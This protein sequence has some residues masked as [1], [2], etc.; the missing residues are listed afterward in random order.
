MAL[1]AGDI[2]PRHQKPRLFQ[3][4]AADRVHSVVH[5]PAGRY[6]TIRHHQVAVARICGRPAP[7]PH[8]HA[9]YRD[10]APRVTPTRLLNSTLRRFARRRVPVD[11]L[12]HADAGGEQLWWHRRRRSP[13]F[14]VDEVMYHGSPC[15]RC[16]RRREAARRAIAARA[17]G[18]G[19]SPPFFHRRGAAR[20]FKI[21]PP[22]RP[23]AR[24]SGAA[25]SAMRRTA[26]GY[27]A[28]RR[29]TAI[30][31][32][33][34]PSPVR[35]RR[36]MRIVA[37]TNIR[38]SASGRRRAGRRASHRSRSSAGAWGRLRAGI[39]ARPAGLR[40]GDRGSAHRTRR[41]SCARTAT[42][43]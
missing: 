19:A 24:R 33:R 3:L 30:S 21:A 12:H 23:G 16:W 43:T 27:D 18:S 42:T 36:R 37:S 41:Q 28:L 5:R 38:P 32:G 8:R 17:G 26:S 10:S 35:E 34:S 6:A 39:P 29:D 31:K 4:D 14:A 20:R 22:L 11:V 1:L 9:A 13:W 15:S 40:G 25:R 2:A 7:E